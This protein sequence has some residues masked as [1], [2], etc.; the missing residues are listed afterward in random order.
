M[1]AYE[2]AK[3]AL[4]CVL[5]AKKGE[6]LIIFCDASKA[7]IGEAFEKEHFPCS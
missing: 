2:A 5:E 1:E 3:N 6:K 4:K 7:L